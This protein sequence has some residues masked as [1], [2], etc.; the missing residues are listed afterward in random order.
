MLR[1]VLEP[2]PS[3]FDF[4]NCS[5]KS[6]ATRSF[7]ITNVTAEIVKFLICKHENFPLLLSHESGVLAVKRI[8]EIGISYLYQEWESIA[9]SIILFI[10]GKRKQ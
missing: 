3:E 8:Q 6:N 10:N 4:G 9:S 2:F 7:T 1:V 5:V